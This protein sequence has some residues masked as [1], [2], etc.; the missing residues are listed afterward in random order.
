MR[1]IEPV[2][3]RPKRPI[4]PRH[5]DLPQRTPV[6]IQERVVVIKQQIE[7]LRGQRPW[8]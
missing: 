6:T 7:F 4:Q 3:I 5:V 1:K 8:A 2:L